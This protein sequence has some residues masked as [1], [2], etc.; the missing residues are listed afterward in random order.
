MHESSDSKFLRS[1]TGISS[2]SD[3]FEKLKLVIILGIDW[4]FHMQ[5]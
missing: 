3:T 1:T 2:R 5:F 4:M